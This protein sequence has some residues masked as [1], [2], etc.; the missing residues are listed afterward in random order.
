MKQLY[1]P[2]RESYIQTKDPKVCPFCVQKDAHNDEKHFIL[3]RFTHCYAMLNLFPYNAGHLLIIPYKHE[4]SLE[5]LSPEVHHE[6]M[7]IASMSISILKKTL[8]AQGIN[9]GL[10]QG[11]AAA[12]GSI[13]EH[14]H[15]HVLPRWLSDTNFLVTLSNTKQIS[16]DL[17]KIYDQLKTAFTQHCKT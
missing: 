12:G 13:P 15:L 2:W 8:G 17:H 5:L 10:N 6:L 14:L 4:G 9:M 16:F 11:G 7:D 3:R 1:A